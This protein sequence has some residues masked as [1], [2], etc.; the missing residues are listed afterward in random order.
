MIIANVVIFGLIALLPVASANPVG[1]DTLMQQ[2]MR[3]PA[4]PECIAARARARE[5]KLS[6]T[7]TLYPPH[8]STMVMPPL[9][10]PKSLRQNGVNMLFTFRVDSAG[11][12]IPDKS[13]TTPQVSESAYQK[14]LNAMMRETK[15]RAAILDGC[16]VEGTWTYRWMGS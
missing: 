3:D 7:D 11:N 8:P 6:A 5:G 2:G 13:V 14:K 15:F 9:P 16:R 1:I 12:V 10:L 4:S